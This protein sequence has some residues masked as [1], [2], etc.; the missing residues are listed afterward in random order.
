M[1]FK[2]Y[3]P[4]GSLLINLEVLYD[5][6]DA[7]FIHKEHWKIRYE[8][9]RWRVVSNNNKTPNHSFARFIWTKN[10]GDISKDMVVD[11]INGNSLDNRKQNL[12]LCSRQENNRNSAPR[13]NSTSKYK[14]VSWSTCKSKWTV[15]IRVNGKSKHIG[16][17]SD[18]K[19]A[20]EAYNK[21]AKQYYGDFAWINPT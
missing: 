11:H 21:A 12:R 8:S 17:F 3:S 1:L 6:E 15:K 14:G 5:I 20:A 9:N 19:L 2:I 10:F 7:K 13:K 18:E 16:Y 4:N